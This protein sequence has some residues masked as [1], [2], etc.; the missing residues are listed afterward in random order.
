MVNND[1]NEL[2]VDSSDLP[3]QYK[4]QEDK[5]LTF[6]QAK[7]Y[8]SNGKPRGRPRKSST[9][10]QAAYIPTGKPRGRPKK[11]MADKSSELKSNVSNKHT[12]NDVSETESDKPPLKKYAS[13]SR[14]RGR[15]KKGREESSDEK[16]I[17]DSEE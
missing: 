10:K 14:P 8:I 16:D 2:D 3:D 4:L 5:K 12:D 1:R 9:S 15:P 7:K 17:S 11:I 13:I 6:V